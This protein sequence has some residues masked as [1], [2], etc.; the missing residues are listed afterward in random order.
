MV[1]TCV[2]HP[3]PRH[4]CGS[5]PTGTARGSPPPCARACTA[6]D[7][8]AARRA[9]GAFRQSDPGP[10]APPDGGGRGRG[11]GRG[12]SPSWPSPRPCAGSP[13]HHQRDRVAEPPSRAVRREPR[14]LPLRRGGGPNCCGRRSATPE[15]PPGRGARQGE[16]HARPLAQGQ[17]VDSSRDRSPPT[18]SRPWPSSP[19][20]TPTESTPISDRTRL[21]RNIDRLPHPS[22]P[23]RPPH[24]SPP[25]ARTGRRRTG[26]PPK[27]GG[28]RVTFTPRPAPLP[29]RNGAMTPSPGRAEAGEH[30]K[31]THQPPFS[32]PPRP[33]TTP[34]HPQEPAPTTTRPRPP[35]NTPDAPTNRPPTPPQPE[36]PPSAK[37]APRRPDARTG[38]ATRP[39]RPAPSRR[40]RPPEGYSASSGA[41]RPE[42]GIAVHEIAGRP[43]STS[44]DRRDRHLTR[45]NVPLADDL[46]GQVTISRVK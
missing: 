22:H 27:K 30:P 37:R 21:H 10:R 31:V 39:V 4:P 19:P 26:R 2:V 32:V 9:P 13:L 35:P 46:A 14:P 42:I 43:A 15:G 41:R 3:G 38:T 5:S 28:R 17:R 7:E 34:T 11:P 12:S 20:P 36:P 45:E 8:E 1:P 25:R 23:S 33:R 18:G 24:P 40:S 29:P 16:E 6:P 44:L